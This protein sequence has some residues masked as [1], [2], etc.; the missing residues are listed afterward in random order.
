MILGTAQRYVTRSYVLMTLVSFVSLLAF[1]SIFEL[2]E[3]ARIV[4]ERHHDFSLAL[5]LTGINLGK[6]AGE[7]APL[8]MLLSLFILGTQLSR[9]GELTALFASGMAPMRLFAPLIFVSALFSGGLFVITDQVGPR[10]AVAIDHIILGELGRWTQIEAYFNGARHWFRIGDHLIRIG[11]ADAKANLYHG[12]T[13]FDVQDGH[14]RSRI[15]AE[16]VLPQG[17]AI[18]AFD[19]LSERYG[20]KGELVFE[21]SDER[22]IVLGGT[23][24]AFFDMS[25]RPTKMTLSE[26]ERVYKM[27]RRQG[28]NPSLH[29]EEYYARLFFP[30]TVFS[31]VL[32]SL[33]FAFQSDVKRSIIVAASEC[34]GLVGIMFFTLQFFRSLAISRAISPQFG[35]IAPMLLVLFYGLYRLRESVPPLSRLPDKA[36]TD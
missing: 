10:A 18:V 25:S 36:K 32:I 31:L 24:N 2:A 8:S 21:R 20:K 33:S 6:L 12:V 22:R 5:H 7:V 29:E 35:A 1:F 17:D 28:Y 23:L 30:G 27:R 14:V 16:K 26:L 15:E 3:F 13:V 19:S 4:S 9:R 34:V 11:E